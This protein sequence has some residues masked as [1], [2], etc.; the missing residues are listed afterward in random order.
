MYFDKLDCMSICVWKC[1]QKD[2]RQTGNA[3]FCRRGTGIGGSGKELTMCD[4]EYIC[5]F[6]SYPTTQYL[7]YLLWECIC[8][9]LCN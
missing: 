3:G 9:P 2:S 8:A 6:P 5:I 1:G 4:I 7:I